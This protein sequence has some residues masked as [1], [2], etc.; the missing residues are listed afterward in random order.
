MVS[1]ARQPT[2]REPPAPRAPAVDPGALGHGGHDPL[3][4]WLGTGKPRP[5]RIAA[6]LAADLAPGAG[7]VSFR[8][9]DE[10]LTIE[11][12]RAHGAAA[13]Q[14]VPT[15]EDADHRLAPEPELLEP[16]L[17]QR[18]SHE[19]DVDLAGVKLLDMQ[20][21]CAEAERQFDLRV[22]ASISSDDR[23]GDATGERSSQ[24]HT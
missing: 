18:R 5:G 19:P 11:V 22:L 16:R 14:P 17:L 9:P 12:A 13:G 23:T 2:D 20:H 4:L 21:R 3:L 8:P 24:T 6:D 1:A 7:A 15:R 10:R